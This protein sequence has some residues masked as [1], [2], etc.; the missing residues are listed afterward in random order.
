MIK[1]KE[2]FNF[3]EPTLNTTKFGLIRLS[4]YNSVFNVNGRNNQFL[5]ENN[6]LALIPGAYELTEI[7]ELK[8]EETNGNVIIDPDKNTINYIMETKQDTHKIDVENSIAS[9]LRLRKIVFERDK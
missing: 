2:K 1:S 6:I 5:Y 3:S 4:V 7:A 8:K 9:L